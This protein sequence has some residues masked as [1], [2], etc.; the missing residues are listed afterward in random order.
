MGLVGADLAELRNLVVQLG[1]PMRVDVDD[2]LAAMNNLVQGSSAYWVAADGDKFR[3][4]FVSFVHSTKTNMDAS[5]QQAAKVTGQN[6]AAIENATESQ[7]LLP[8]FEPGH[9]LEPNWD[10]LIPDGEGHLTSNEEGALYFGSAGYLFSKYGIGHR[11]LLPES[12]DSPWPVIPRADNLPPGDEITVLGQ[13]WV[14]NDSGILVPAAAPGVDPRVPLPPENLGAGWKTGVDGGLRVDPVNV[15]AW[16]E[17][18]SRG[19]FVVG[20]GLTLYSTW[21]QAWQGDQALHPNWSEPA[22]IADAAGQTAVEGGATI[23]GAWAGAELGAEGGAAAGAT[24]GSI[25]PVGG[26]VVGG[27]VGGLAGGVV[28]GFVGS[29]VGQAV[30]HGLWDG[31]KAV[32]GGLEDAGSAIGSLLP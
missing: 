26:T 2:V 22:R 17:Y 15:P 29:Q 20:S 9:L 31:G 13:Q 21:D 32:V 30:G 28:G 23:G 5:L 7:A 10:N 6:L 12:P 3:A 14:G 8:Y 18:G 19:L 11:V 1:G 27:V 24:I 4:D 25:I 16:A